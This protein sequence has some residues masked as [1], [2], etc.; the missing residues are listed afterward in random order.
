MSTNKR[1]HDN[2]VAVG[3][4]EDKT[5]QVLIPDG[6]TDKFMWRFI[7]GAG[8]VT[9]SGVVLYD[10]IEAAMAA[11]LAIVMPDAVQ[12]KYTEP[13]DLDYEALN[14]LLFGFRKSGGIHT[15]QEAITGHSFLH[16]ALETLKLAAEK[17]P[18]DYDH[19][20][21]DVCIWYDDASQG[22]ALIRQLKELAEQSQAVMIELCERDLETLA[23]FIGSHLDL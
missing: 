22:A 9:T 10:S 12:V 3:Q 8:K 13:G 23:A 4:V 18:Q 6:M 15:F 16:S 14:T 17:L 21:G 1:K 2:V 19:L 7:D 5:V 11:V 20:L